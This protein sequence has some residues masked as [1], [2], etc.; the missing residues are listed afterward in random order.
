MNDISK[1]QICINTSVSAIDDNHLLEKC[2]IQYEILKKYCKSV[3]RVVTFDF[4][5]DNVEGLK[6]SKIQKYLLSNEN[7]IDTVFRPSRNNELV[8]KNIINVKKG[9]FMGKQ[10]LMSKYNK[11]TYVGK[12]DGCLEMCGTKLIQ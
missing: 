11:K 12:C 6:Y 4:N 9:N 1:Y 7:V 5:L 3:L 2:I 8:Y 10:T